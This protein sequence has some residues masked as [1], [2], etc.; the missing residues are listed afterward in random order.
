[1][2]SGSSMV[3]SRTPN[4]VDV[5]S[6]RTRYAPDGWLGTLGQL[7]YALD[8]FGADRDEDG[9]TKWWGEPP[10]SFMGM[11]DDQT[12]VVVHPSAEVEIMGQRNPV[13]GLL[14]A[15]SYGRRVTVI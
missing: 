3:E 4:P 9:K 6:S 8:T 11:D 13:V 10:V 1:M 7:R 5:R 15:T 14:G 12:D 2:C